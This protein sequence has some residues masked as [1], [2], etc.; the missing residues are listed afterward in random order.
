MGKFLI[1]LTATSIFLS[2]CGDHG[3]PKNSV[4]DSA[5]DIIVTEAPQNIPGIEKIAISD[6]VALE[7][8][9]NMH[10]DK[11]LFKVKAGRKIWL[12]LSNKPKHAGMSMTHNA[13]NLKKVT[14][15]ADFADAVKNAKEEN[16]V[17]ASVAPLVI[18]HTRM[19]SAGEADSVEFMLPGAGVYDFI[20]SF[21]GHWGTMQGKI[22]AE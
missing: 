11:E 15:I 18:A 6:T 13:V 9:E 22:V 10:F 14:D 16:Y 8:D 20:C 19:V 3:S 4:S 1:I 17:P 12:I 5:K 21:P 7:A 2:G